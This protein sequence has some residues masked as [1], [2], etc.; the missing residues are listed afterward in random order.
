MYPDTI[1]MFYKSYLSNADSVRYPH[2]S[3]ITEMSSSIFGGTMN[4]TLMKYSAKVT[5]DF[6]SMVKNLETTRGMTVYVSPFGTT[7][8]Y[9]GN[10]TI[11][12]DQSRIFGALL[13]GSASSRPPRL[14]ITYAKP[15]Y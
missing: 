3:A 13:K 5:Y 8:D 10:T 11:G 9:Y 15:K 4:K 12:V 7:Y 14:I 1:G 6:T 2:A